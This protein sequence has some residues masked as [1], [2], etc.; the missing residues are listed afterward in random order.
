MRL[1]Y[2]YVCSLIRSIKL[3]DGCLTF[4]T[5][6]FAH[7]DFLHSK[8]KYLQV[9]PEGEVVNIPDIQLKLAGVADGVTAIDLC[10]A[11]DAWTDFV[12]A[13]L[14]WGVKGEIVHQ[15]DDK[16]EGM[17]FMLDGMLRIY[18]LSED[19]REITLLTDDNGATSVL[20]LNGFRNGVTFTYHPDAEHIYQLHYLW[21]DNT[22]FSLRWLQAMMPFTALAAATAGEAR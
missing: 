18:I 17:L 10:P 13:H 2:F 14:F 21:E 4:G 1:C 20:S 5:D 16:C 11:R 12:A 19:G 3:T 8:E 9:E 22:V 6:S 7:K 15:P